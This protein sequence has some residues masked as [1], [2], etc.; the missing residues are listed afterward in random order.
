MRTLITKS[1]NLINP[2]NS[3][4]DIRKRIWL[5]NRQVL[6]YFNAGD[7]LKISDD[8]ETIRVEV[9]DAIDEADK[10]SYRTVSYRKR[11]NKG[12]IEISDTNCARLRDI[13]AG[14]LLRIVL[15]DGLMTIT[16]AKDTL[17][18]SMAKSVEQVKGR[19]ARGEPL[20]V[21]SICAGGGTFDFCLHEGFSRAGQASVVKYAI[22]YESQCIDN[23]VMNLPYLF[24]AQ[25]VLMESDLSKLNFS[26]CA[27]ALK[28]VDVCLCTPPC[29][30]ACSA[31][32]AKK[33]NKFETSATSHLVYFYS[34]L[35]EMA[36]PAVIMFENSPNFANEV[37]YHLLKP[38]LEVF[39]YDVQERVINAREEGFSLETR[40]RLFMYAELKLLE[41]GFKMHDIQPLLATPTTL[42]S[43]LNLDAYQD[44][45]LWSSKSYLFDKQ[46]RDIEAGKG[47][48]VQI[49]TPD[50]DRIPTLRAGYAKGGS[51]DPLLAHSDSSKALYRLLKADEAC[52]VK[53]FPVEIVDGVSD[54]TAHQL[55]GNGIEGNVGTSFAF[56]VGKALK[57]RF[58]NNVGQLVA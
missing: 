28:D 56:Y 57:S 8:G 52:R 25:S 32:K 33:G 17:E 20:K 14:Q 29:T 45:A 30:D 12:L 48:R 43:C 51:T 40:N 35:I 18:Q 46:E 1:L 27:E 10:H 3:E 44:E 19:I 26:Q 6:H 41:T 36:R 23:L 31:G 49:V 9:V 54:T 22:D 53:H 21:M 15:S 24:D 38:L 4:S 2:K 5:E 7:L 34:K 11:S 50:S 58:A 37:S 39:G 55:L 42:R 47:F 13:D 16:V